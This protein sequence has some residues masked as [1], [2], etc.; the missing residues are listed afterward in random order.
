[1]ISASSYKLTLPSPHASAVH[2]KG[3]MINKMPG[4]AWQKHANLR[5]LYGYMFTHPGKKHLFMG[6]EIAQWREWNHDAQVDWDVLSDPQHEGMQRWV[7]DLNRV[8]GAERSL[9]D[10]DFDGRGFRWIDANDNSNSVI[11]FVRFADDVSDH[12]V[13]VVNLTPVP[14][15]G[16]RIGVPRSGPYREVLNSDA[17][18]YGGSDLGNGGRVNALAEPSHGFE[19]SMTLTLPP[20]GFLL[21]KPE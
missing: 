16:Y 11:S 13:V 3:S 4:D 12:T 1:L 7:R 8:Y 9:A 6:C 2:G 18:I 20:L 14:R 21:L 10:V 15:E 19:C 17:G 5:A